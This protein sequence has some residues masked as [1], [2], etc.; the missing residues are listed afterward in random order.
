[1]VRNAAGF[2][3]NLQSLKAQYASA[4]PFPHVVIDN[5]LESE[6]S[7][8]AA[9]EFAELD[10]GHWIGYVHVNEKKFSNPR[11]DTWGPTLQSV[12]QALNSPDFIRLLTELTGIKGLIADDAMEGGGLHKSLTGGFLNIHADF[13][14]HPLRPTWRRRVNLLLYFNQEWPTAYGGEL[15]LWSSDM[16]R[17]EKSISPIANRAVIFSTERDSF[18]GHPEPLRGPQGIARKSLA[19]Y[20]FTVEDRPE[21]RSTEYRPRPGEGIR[22]I[23][24]FLDKHVLRIY[25]RMKRRLG[26]SDQ[27]MDQLIRRIKRPPGGRKP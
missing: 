10:P 8:R 6:V 27:R 12:A 13:T 2:E 5:F 11:T 9:A 16:K 25:D 15:E 26:I 7:A 18:H 17:C 14:V 24:I 1:M 4:E 3:A 20:Y 21:V 23:P 22:G 19:L